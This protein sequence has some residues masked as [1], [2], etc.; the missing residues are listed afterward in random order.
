MDWLRS[1][2]RKEE[3]VVTNLGVNCT[4]RKEARLITI[5]RRH[6]RTREITG[7]YGEKKTKTIG[8]KETGA[9]VVMRNEKPSAEEERRGLQGS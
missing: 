4:T 8:K 1:E 2:D 6:Q 9:E 7:V 5:D 3:T